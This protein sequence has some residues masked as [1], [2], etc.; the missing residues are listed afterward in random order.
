MINFV[1]LT[2][3]IF[4]ILNNFLRLSQLMRCEKSLLRFLVDTMIAPKQK[5]TYSRIDF[6]DHP[7]FFSMHFINNYSLHFSSHEHFRLKILVNSTNIFEFILHSAHACVSH[8]MK[9][10]PHISIENVHAWW[11][12]VINYRHIWVSWLLQKV[13]H[14]H[15]Y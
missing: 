14:M 7:S 5:K 15:G 8:F 3:F 4:A 12:K 9:L 1:W 10:F 6:F 2:Q 13:G 11:F